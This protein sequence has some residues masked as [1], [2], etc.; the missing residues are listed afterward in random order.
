MTSVCALLSFYDET[1]AELHRLIASLPT[2]GVTH[3]VALDGRYAAFYGEHDTSSHEAHEAI[4]Q[5]C[6]TAGMGLTLHVDGPWDSEIAKRTFLFGLAAQQQHDWLMVVDGDEEV[7]AVQGDPAAILRA[8]SLDVA[9]VIL[10]R[11]DG[12]TQDAAHR[13]YFRALPG[14]HVAG[15]HY[16]YRDHA[17]RNLWGNGMAVQLEPAQPLRITV[18]HHQRDTVRRTRKLGYYLV[19]DRSGIE[20][21]GA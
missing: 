14:L 20:T 7:A 12:S 2:V 21:D 11:P 19:R 8:T 15:N 16:T 5:A 9:T 6:D 13:M 4:K 3:L 10:E 18:L 17:G 1:P